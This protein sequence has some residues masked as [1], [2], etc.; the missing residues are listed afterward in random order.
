MGDPT[1]IVVALCLGVSQLPKY[2]GKWFQQ[3]LWVSPQIYNDQPCA[4]LF[5]VADTDF[6][7]RALEKGLFQDM[8]AATK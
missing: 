5:D 7:S 6:F 8:S 3:N 4:F 1:I 2:N